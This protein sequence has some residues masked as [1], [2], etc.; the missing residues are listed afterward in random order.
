ME[1]IVNRE[2]YYYL[3]T[4]PGQ[5]KRTK[6]DSITSYNEENFIYGPFISDSENTDNINLSEDENYIQNISKSKKQPLCDR[7]NTESDLEEELTEDDLLMEDLFCG[8]EADI[9]R[10]NI[11]ETMEQLPTSNHHS[12]TMMILLSNST[13][14]FYLF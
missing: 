7:F 8:T 5:A 12:T 14:S 6:I 9:S 10:T 3:R 4:H 13:I 1:T 11:N 2:G